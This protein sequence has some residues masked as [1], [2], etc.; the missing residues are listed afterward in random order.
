MAQPSQY[1]CVV[2]SVRNNNARGIVYHRA[3]ALIFNPN[4]A[5][6]G[7]TYDPNYHGPPLDPKRLDY[8]R[9]KTRN[10]VFRT[11]EGLPPVFQDCLPSRAGRKV[12]EKLEPSFAGASNALLLQHMGQVEINGV[13]LE[14]KDL[15]FGAAQVFIANST[16]DRE[17]FKRLH[18]MSEYLEDAHSVP[19]RQQYRLRHTKHNNM[20]RTGIL[21]DLGMEFFAKFSSRTAPYSLPRMESVIL[22]TLQTANFEV[23]EHR[24]LTVD[25]GEP[26]LAVRRFDVRDNAHLHTMPVANVL[27]NHVNDYRGVRALIQRVSTNKQGDLD[28]LAQTVVADLVF[29]NTD[30]HFNN[31]TLIA[32]N[33]GYRLSPLYDRLPNP[34]RARFETKIA[35]GMTDLAQQSTLIHLAH[36]LGLPSDLLEHHAYNL[37][38]AIRHL[39]LNAIMARLAPQ[40]WR[41]LKQAIAV[42][43]PQLADCLPDVLVS[44]R[45]APAKTAHQNAPGPR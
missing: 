17:F 32:D 1:S 38:Q 45:M 39:P 36:R 30:N 13:R 27:G 11:R 14:T 43:Q 24:L 42:N 22:T 31:M 21:D 10:F 35:D 26:M 15:M 19:A 3:G 8:K 2:V 40:D 37:Y 28:R 18:A 20:P 29:N 41:L 7:F 33:D 25:N 34:V 5:I 9:A 12:L 6:M 23:P 4:A 44:H 16:M